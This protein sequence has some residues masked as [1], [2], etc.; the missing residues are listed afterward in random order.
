MRRLATLLALLLP[1]L[2]AAVARAA[3][4]EHVAGD[5]ANGTRVWW[6]TPSAPPG[7]RAPVVVVLHGFG[8]LDPVP[9]RALIDHETAR[10]RIVI[11]PQFLRGDLGFL[12]END[13]RVFLARAQAAVRT[14]LHRIGSRARRSDLVLWGHSLGG[15][16]AA[17]WNPAGPK[18][19]ALVLAHPSLG[20]TSP[21]AVT[22]IPIAQLAPQVRAPATILTGSVDRIA[23][24]A[25]S[26]TLYRLLTH[27]R[28]REVWEARPDFGGWPP[29]YPWHLAPLAPPGRFGRLDRRF[30]STALDEAL[31]RRRPRFDFGRRPSG[32][33][34]LGPV[35]LAP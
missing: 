30:Y 2:P 33:R 35:R 10:G 3:V 4:T 32:R 18:A 24:P 17:A 15:L 7:H 13:Q 20:T 25:E 6:W 29:V 8:V 22:P 34:V 27:A 19:R 9:Y 26:L 11:Y 23:P 31:A 5:A 28:R 21:V 16:M 14:A 1:L 12:F